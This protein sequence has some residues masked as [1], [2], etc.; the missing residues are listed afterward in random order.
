LALVEDLVTISKLSMKA[1]RITQAAVATTVSPIPSEDIEGETYYTLTGPQ[2][3]A[4]LAE[5]AAVIAQIKT[6][7][8]GLP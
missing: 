4:K 5:R 8:A 2:R 7:A 6:L 3:A 1:V